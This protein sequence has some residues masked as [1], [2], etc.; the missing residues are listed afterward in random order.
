MASPVTGQDFRSSSMA[1]TIATLTL[2]DV[3]PMSPSQGNGVSRSDY[4]NRLVSRLHDVCTSADTSLLRRAHSSIPRRAQ[5][6]LDMPDGNFDQRLY[7]YFETFLL[8][9]QIV[10]FP[11]IGCDT[12]RCFQYF[13]RKLWIV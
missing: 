8:T 6:Y 3:F 4:I 9:S 12:L 2:L 1:S 10:F 7:K 13:S 11:C 5:D